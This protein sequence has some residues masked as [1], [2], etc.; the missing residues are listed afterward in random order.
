MTTHKLAQNLSYVDVGF[1]PHDMGVTVEHNG[2]RYRPEW[3]LI[4]DLQ[5]STAIFGIPEFWCTDGRRIHFDKPAGD[6]Y[7][8][9]A[10][11]LKMMVRLTHP[12]HGV[13]HAYGAR[14]LADYLAAGWA[15]AEAQDRLEEPRPV[16]TLPEKRKPG[17]PAKAE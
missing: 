9:H 1:R 4:S 10:E 7:L 2:K 6:D 13:T 5:H 11:A 17:R 15:Q 12:Q 14:E 8:V 16:L 3:R